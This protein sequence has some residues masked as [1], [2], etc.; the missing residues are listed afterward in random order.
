MLSIKRAKTDPWQSIDEN[1]HVGQRIDV[2]VKSIV[3]YGAFVEFGQGMNGLVHTNE[4]TIQKH[5]NP[6]DILSIGDVKPA[7]IISIDKEKRRMQLSAM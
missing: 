3:D 1:Y 5:I 7:E 4:L 2:T 6:K